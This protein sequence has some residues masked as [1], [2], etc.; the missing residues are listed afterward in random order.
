MKLFYFHYYAGIGI[1]RILPHDVIKSL[2]SLP[3]TL[4]LTVFL[5]QTRLRNALKHKE[6]MKMFTGTISTD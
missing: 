3:H 1:L 6:V 2:T 4:L 5:I